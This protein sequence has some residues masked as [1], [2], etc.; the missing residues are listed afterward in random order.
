MAITGLKQSFLYALPN[1]ITFVISDAGA[2]DYKLE[3][4]VTQ[5]IMKKQI[6]VN[7]LLSQNWCY[8]PNNTNECTI[9]NRL[10]LVSGGKLFNITGNELENVIKHLER[11]LD[12]NHVKLISIISEA[13]GTK[14]QNINVDQ[15]IQEICA[16]VSGLNP[17]LVALGPNLERVK[18]ISELTMATYKFGCI[19][20]SEPGQYQF[21]ITANS[22]F[23][24]SFDARSSLTFN[25]GFSIEPV[26]LYSETNVQPLTGPKNILTIFPSDPTLITTLSDI[27]VILDT[28]GTNEKHKEINLLLKKVN[29]G[30]YAT[31]AFEI[32]KERFKIRMR[33]LDSNR[34][35][36]DREICEMLSAVEGCMMNFY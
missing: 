22:S 7:F 17:T 9:Y 2:K 20:S 3:D 23:V 30:V 11:T 33:G 15:S 13:A 4:E 24:T 1:S 18:L 25:F 27:L 16:G 10:A 14:Q 31:E 34:I 35:P 28:L 32:P 26:Q 6:T 19:N 8:R 12:P 21:E 5:V 36:I 29:D